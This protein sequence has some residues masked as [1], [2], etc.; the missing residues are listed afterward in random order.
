MGGS[1][2]RETLASPEFPVLLESTVGLFINGSVNWFARNEQL[3]IFSL[4]LQ[5]ETSQYLSLPAGFDEVLHDQPALAVL[6]GC[7]CLCYDHMQT[8]FVLWE[9]REFGVQDS[10]TRL[11]NVSY[12]H[13]QFDNI[14]NDWLLVPVCL[15]ENDVLLLVSKEVPDDGIM[16]NLR[17]DRVEHTELPDTNIW[18]ADEHMQSLVVP[19]PHP[20]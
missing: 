18:Y 9:M 10:W 20:H 8:H 6:R 5:K 16:Y 13:L 7:L 3:V 14:Q 15:S 17:D 12:A 1:F 11:V 19:L 4:D 2:W